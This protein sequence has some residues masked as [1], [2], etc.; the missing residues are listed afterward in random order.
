MLPSNSPPLQSMG[1]ADFC[2]GLLRLGT[3]K[4]RLCLAFCLFARKEEDSELPDTPRWT[5]ADRAL[6]CVFVTQ[7]SLPHPRTHGAANR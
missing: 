4:G 1:A 3:Y 7:A 6:G 2:G 5:C